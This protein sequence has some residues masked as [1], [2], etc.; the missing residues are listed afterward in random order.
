MLLML[1]SADPIQGRATS[2][3][4]PRLY[5]N[6]ALP[7]GMKALSIR[8]DVFGILKDFFAILIRVQ[9]ERKSYMN[10]NTLLTLTLL[11]PEVPYV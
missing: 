4:Q 5:A 1:W 3:L 10:F 2:G 8:I 6:L 9:N 11:M 7:V